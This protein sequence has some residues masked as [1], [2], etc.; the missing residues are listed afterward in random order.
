MFEIMV[1]SIMNNK[2]DNIL[3]QSI[4]GDN[5]NLSLIYHSSLNNTIKI[6]HLTKT[7][8]NKIICIFGV[9]VNLKGILIENEMLDWLLPEYD[10]YCV[11]Q[12]YPGKLYEYPYFRFAQWL[13]QTLNETILLYVHTK[14]AFNSNQ[15]QIH[16]RTLWMNEF[17]NPRNKIYIQPILKNKT[18][19][20]V[21]FRAGV[22]T[23]F[24]GMFISKRAFDLIPEVPIEKMRHFYEGGVFN[25]INIRIKGKIK[26][27][28]LP[29]EIGKVMLHHLYIKK[30]KNE[31]GIIFF[32]NVLLLGLLI[33]I[34]LYINNHFKFIKHKKEKKKI[35]IKLLD[36][37]K[38]FHL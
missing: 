1:L 30:H 29:C 35:P 33:I 21:P 13:S 34:K 9:L 8:T 22:C 6:K 5:Y 23:W 3:F 28:I 20:T 4:I 11:Y 26:D 31:L 12:K 24:N 37:I 36:K 19:I 25:Y 38:I 15:I 2:L 10:I 14:G 16:V 27:R 7:K 17:K 32:Q 18:D